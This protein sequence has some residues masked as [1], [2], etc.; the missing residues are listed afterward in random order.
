MHPETVHNTRYY[1]VEQK[2]LASSEL[3]I[4]CRPRKPSPNFIISYCYSRHKGLEMIQ[5]VN[6]QYLNKMFEWVSS[7]PSK[8]K[9]LFMNFMFC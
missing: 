1:V 3:L 4:V 7:R 2:H 5:L 8:S 9:I 6:K